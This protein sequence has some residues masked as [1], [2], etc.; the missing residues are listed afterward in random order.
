M[1]PLSIRA[2]LDNGLRNDA[3]YNSIIDRLNSLFTH[4]FD[5]LIE[6]RNVYYNNDIHASNR[7]MLYDSDLRLN[8]PTI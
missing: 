4:P 5:S 2:F 7:F 3:S 8:D 6:S 1:K